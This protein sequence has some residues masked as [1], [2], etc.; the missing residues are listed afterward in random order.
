MCVAAT[1]RRRRRQMRNGQRDRR[2]FATKHRALITGSKVAEK[3]GK[4]K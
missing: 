4:K 3:K 1:C 2:F